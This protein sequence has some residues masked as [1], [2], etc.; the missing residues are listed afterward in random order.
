[1]FV[2]VVGFG[3][4]LLK[5]AYFQTE[6]TFYTLSFLVFIEFLSL[7]KKPSFSN[8]IIVGVLAA[9]A[10]LAKATMLMGLAIF[11]FYFLI[12][13]GFLAWNKLKNKK[14]IKKNLA[15]IAIILVTF[16]SITLPELNF[17]K[18]VFGKYF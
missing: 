10:Y 17:N 2:L 4:Y 5:S 18:R 15:T 14:A 3:L 9:L 12:E 7:I 8:A 1:M 13:K 6:L 16:I 11:T